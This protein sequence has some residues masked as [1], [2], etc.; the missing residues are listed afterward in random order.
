MFVHEDIVNAIQ[1]ECIGAVKGSVTV[2]TD[3]RSDGP[4]HMFCALRGER[5]DA[6]SFISGAVE[7]GVEGI[8]VDHKVDCAIP[9]YIVSD[10]L[11]AY[12]ALGAFNRAR[13]QIPFIG[14]TGTNGKTTVKELI[15]T[16]LETCGSPFCSKNNFNNHV[17][18]PF[19][20][21]NLDSTYSHAVIEMGMNHP[22]EIS[23]LTHLARP[24]VA[25]ITCIGRAHM[26]FM[27]TL[28][29]VA[30]A[31]AEIFEGM[32]PG[33][34][35]ILPR[36][37]AYYTQL[38][39]AALKQ[40]LHVVSF[41][42]KPGAD[43]HFAVDSMTTE[44]ITGV[45]HTPKGT[46]SVTLQ[47]SGKHNAANAAAATA[48]ALAVEP[49]LSLDQIMCA[50]S[51]A[52]S[53][54]MRCQVQENK[55]I[56]IILDC[57]NANPDSSRAALQ[58]LADVD[59]G[60]KRCCLFGD[61]HEL[62]KASAEMHEEIGAFAAE[63]RINKIAV[64]GEFK[65]DTARGALRN[66]MDQSAVITC[67]SSEEVLIWLRKELQSG[68]IVLVKGSRNMK[69]EKII[70]IWCADSADND[71]DENKGITGTR[72]ENGR[73]TLQQSPTPKPNTNSTFAC[74][75]SVMVPQSPEGP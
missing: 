48:A 40:G 6:H 55:G 51:R 3:S 72:C 37:D 5:Y 73:N 59:E 41:G 13:F 50:F 28:D 42:T 62:G 67:D 46:T 9:Q 2:T 39:S 17:G 1:P 68:D 69:L 15:F 53:V 56:K 24:D 4:G 34:T 63:K 26:E 19:T 52:V 66:G 65:N 70:D 61:M 58:L 57:Y 44:L 31:K 18:V 25:V 49:C 10:T 75:T 11:K 21:L 30:A 74:Y 36:Q 35:A 7:N 29:A 27:K 45:M 54:D 20:L 64:L 38:K 33:G 47:M 22:G 14:V 71:K 12:Q 43:V 60:A 23:V 16:L 32:A 8:I